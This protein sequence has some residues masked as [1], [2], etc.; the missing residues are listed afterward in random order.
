[1]HDYVLAAWTITIIPL[2]GRHTIIDRVDRVV[3][4]RRGSSL[5]LGAIRYGISLRTPWHRVGRQITGE[6]MVGGC[7]GDTI[8]RPSSGTIRLIEDVTINIMWTPLTFEYRIEHLLDQW[9]STFPMHHLKVPHHAFHRK[10]PADRYS[11]LSPH[12]V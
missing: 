6:S 11:L 8:R 12:H 3:V 2:A 5:I 10:E 4:D 7:E 9:D 1:M